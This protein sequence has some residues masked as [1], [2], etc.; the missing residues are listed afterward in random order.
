M[1]S[2]DIRRMTCL[3]VKKGNEFVVCRQVGTG[4]IKWSTSPWEAWSTRIR[5]NARSVAEKIDGEVFLFNPVVGQ[6]KK[7]ML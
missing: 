6:I 7:M 3:I 4:L 1:N 2:M 5:A